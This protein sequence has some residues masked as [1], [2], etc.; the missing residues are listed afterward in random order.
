[1]SVDWNK[2][3]QS[4]ETPWEKGEPHPELPFL[5]ST[6]PE[7]LASAASVIVPGCGVGHDAALIR[8]VSKGAVVGLDIADKAIER[9]GA[10]YPELEISWQVADL[11]T[12]QGEYDLVFEHTCFCAIPPDRRPDYV[13][14]MARLIPSGGHLVGIFFLDPDLE[15]EEGPPFGVT[16]EELEGYFSENFSLEWSQ[17]PQKTFESREGEDRELCMVWR[18]K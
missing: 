6:H 8:G 1:M 12:W 17:A 13:E 7:I 9:A 5:L 18:R 3:Y 11:F 14:T 15:G 10:R 4:G 2:R 16:L